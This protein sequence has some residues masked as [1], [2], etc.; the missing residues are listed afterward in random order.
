MTSSEFHYKILLI[1]RFE[2]RLLN[3]FSL[4]KLS[5][6]THSYIGQ[7]AIAVGVLSNIKNSDIIISNHRC[8]GHYIAFHNDIIGLLA[9]I[10]GKD[11]GVSGGR[12]GSQHIHKENFF[13]NGVQG[14]MMPVAAGMAYAKKAEGLGNIV[15]IFLGDGTFGEGTIYE[16]MNMVSLW[17]L[18]VFIVVENNQY[19]Q[20]TSLS[21][22]FS[23]SFSKRINSFDIPSK[24]VTTNDVEDIYKISNNI[25]E[26]IRKN[27]KPFSLIVN[28]Y[29]LGPHSKGDDFRA[30]EEIDEWKKKDP[31]YIIEKKISKTIQKKNETNINRILTEA[32][33]IANAMPDSSRLE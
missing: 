28:T 3:L 32:E 6:T 24:E 29:R 20:S 31:L 14:N 19:A 23:G 27:D 22:N 10:M 21:S 33:E 25:I 12:G 18:P 5:G 26:Q 8:H 17:Q 9:E 15:V 4:G 7:E 16:T 13:S 30:Q 2:E 11:G 1:R